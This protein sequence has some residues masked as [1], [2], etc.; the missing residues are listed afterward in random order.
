M[1]RKKGALELSVGTIVVIVLA[2]TMLILG[3][4]LVRSIMCS[5]V[6]LTGEINTKI[7]GEINK[8]FQSTA[9]EVVCIG[10]GEEPITI[11]PGKIN[12]IYCAIKA[13]QEAEYNIKV[14]SISGN[15]LANRELEKWVVGDDF[16]KGRIAPGDEI[17]KKTLRLQV[18]EE[19]PHDL[20][21]VSVEIYREG[22]LISTQQLDFEIKRIGFFRAAVC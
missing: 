19:A 20:V 14:K 15:I 12:I 21:T 16:W 13:P 11:V 17:P 2:V 18:P 6:G 9:G 22:N 4:V 8:L 3:M 7:K 5:A 1:L 10:S